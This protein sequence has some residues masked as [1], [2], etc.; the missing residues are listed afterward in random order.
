[1]RSLITLAAVAALLTPLS[2]QKF[3]STLPDGLLAQGGN[4]SSGGGVSYCLDPGIFRYQEIHKNW[5]GKQKALRGV[6]FRRGWGRATNTT[7]VARKY[8]LF[9]R[10]GYGD[11]ATYASTSF[12]GNYTRG[13]QVVIGKESPAG[14]TP[15]TVSLPD[16]TKLNPAWSATNPA[17][18]DA[19]MPFTT[20]VFL[21]DGK[22][23]MIWE[24]EI[25]KASVSGGTYNCDRQGTGGNSA[26][27]VGTYVPNPYPACNDSAITSTTGAY[28]FGTAYVYNKSYST[29]SY[30][31]KVRIY[32]YSYRT[33]PGANVAV[34]YSPFPNPTG[35]NMGAICNKLHFDA[36]KPF[37]LLFRPAANTTSAS[38]SSHATTN[39]LFPWNNVYANV[40]IMMQTAWTDSKTGFFSLTAARSFTIPSYP[41]VSKPIDMKYIYKRSTS[42]SNSGPY[43]AGSVI[44][45]WY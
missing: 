44:T 10:L 27:G 1:M 32:N 36:S 7:A 29:V 22:N 28:M 33:A 3:H 11:S 9:F 12:N 16:W 45:G 24:I 6:A 21:Y 5:L 20:A 43:T 38:T 34:A 35:V 15:V 39:L 41:P 2:A 37:H 23:D 26:T 17:P 31:D 40:P 4:Y 18:F 13:R 19:F 30:Q 8:D 42:T 14:N 25:V